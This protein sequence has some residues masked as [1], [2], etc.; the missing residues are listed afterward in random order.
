M[1]GKYIMKPIPC[2]FLIIS[3]LNLYLFIPME[4]FPTHKEVSIYKTLISSNFINS[5]PEAYYS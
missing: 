5:D 3:I 2:I 4:I 1:T